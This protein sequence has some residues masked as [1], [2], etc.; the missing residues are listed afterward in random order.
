MSQSTESW[1]KGK[2][3]YYQ[4]GYYENYEGYEKSN[5]LRE[6]NY[7]DRLHQR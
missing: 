3:G 6:R 7:S 4:D 5:T 2:D 1:A